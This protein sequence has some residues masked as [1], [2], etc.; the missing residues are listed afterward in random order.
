MN[1]LKASPGYGDNE[2]ANEAAAAYA[3]KNKQEPTV[4]IIPA[5]DVLPMHQQEK[6]GGGAYRHLVDK[7]YINLMAN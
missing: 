6:L 7:V 4:A 3:Q 1:I 5:E 2:F